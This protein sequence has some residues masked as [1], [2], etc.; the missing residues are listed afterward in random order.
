[1]EEDPEATKR[2]RVGGSPA[3]V[4]AS[5]M[6]AA[7]RIPFELAYALARLVLEEGG[8]PVAF[9]GKK[10]VIQKPIVTALTK[11]GFIDVTSSAGFEQKVYLLLSVD[12]HLG[13]L[14]ETRQPGPTVTRGYVQD[15]VAVATQAAFDII[16]QHVP[17]AHRDRA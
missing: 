16:A 4:A 10:A 1:M 7:Q 17:R 11:L 9:T 2:R 5:T 13:E 12:R 8:G 6:S 14:I 15:K 3:Y